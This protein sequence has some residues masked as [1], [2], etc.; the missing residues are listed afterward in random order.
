MSKRVLVT[1]DRGMTDKTGKVVWDH[2]IPILNA[3]HGADVTEV[4]LSAVEDLRGTA[5]VL[6]GTTQIVDPKDPRFKDQ[7]KEKV[8]LVEVLKRNLSLGKP[9]SGSVDDEYERLVAMYGTHPDYGLPFVEYVYGR[10]EQGRFHEAVAAVSDDEE[11]DYDL[12][13]PGAK[14]VSL[15]TGPLTDEQMREKLKAAD[16]E[17]PPTAK[18]ATLRKLYDA[19]FA[20]AA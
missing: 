12:A 1:I 19:A 16:I 5:L 9:F 4:D 8:S 18:G 3:V 13:H 17:F 10:P 14:P 6:A 11:H 15:D 20:Q 7:A 2:E